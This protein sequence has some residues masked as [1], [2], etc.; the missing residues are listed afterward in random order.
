MAN[1][2]GFSAEAKKILDQGRQSG[3][4]KSAPALAKAAQGTT[5]GQTGIGM[6]NAGYDFVTQGQFDKGLD[7]MKQGLSKSDLKRPEEAKLH[8]GI[9]YAMAGRNADAISMFKT[10]QGADGSADLARYW[11]MQLSRPSQPNAQQ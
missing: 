10:V 11:V 7:L 2:K 9:A 1:A 8:T 3:I 4:V 5:I 6:V